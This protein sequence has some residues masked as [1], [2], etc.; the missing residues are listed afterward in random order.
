MTRIPAICLNHKCN[1]IFPSPFDLLPGVNNVAFEN[2]G[3]GPCP[4][5][6]ADGKIPDGSYSNFEDKIFASLANVNDIALLKKITN[7]IKRDL[8]RDIS[9]KNI[10]KKLNKQ[11]PK[12]KTAWN[13]IPETKQDAYTVIKIILA[14]T[15]AIAAI[16]SCSKE[17]KE[18]IIN[19][20]YNNLYLHDNPAPQQNNPFG[21]HIE[22]NHKQD[23]LVSI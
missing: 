2:I 9:P 18:I 23:K 11:F 8:S 1:T 12:Q 16:G 6:G 4:K 22:D 7:T 17:N 15:V 13:L 19:Q 21:I 3:I 10:K 14:L 5:C 20:T